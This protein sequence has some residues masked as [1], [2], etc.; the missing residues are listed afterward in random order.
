MKIFRW[1][2]DRIIQIT[3]FVSGAVLMSLEIVGAR[4]LIPFYGDT[5]YVWG[6]IIGIFL[7]SL[8]LGY[9][10][11]GKLADKKP[12]FRTLSYVLILAG[13]FV[14]LIPFIY[15]WVV[16]MVSGSPKPLAPFLAVLIIFFIP[17]LLHGVVSPFAIKLKARN[18]N[19]IGEL[20][21]GLYALSTLGSVFGTFLTTFI[22]IF[23]MPIHSIYYLLGAIL[24]LIALLLSR[25]N[26]LIIAVIFL[27]MI[28]QIGLF[29][30]SSDL[31]KT[32][33]DGENGATASVLVTKESLYGQIKVTEQEGVR[34]LYLNNGIMGQMW[35]EDETAILPG[36]EYVSC[37]EYP[38]TI[39]PKIKNILSLGL[40]IGMIGKSINSKYDVSLDV[41]EL[42]Q[43]VINVAK[44]YFNVETSENFKIY[45]DDAR[46]FLQNSDTKYDLIIMDVLHF[47]PS[48]GYQ[49]PFH[50]TT[51]E[52]FELVKEHL[53][54]D[55]IFSS[56]IVGSL[57]GP[58][59][60]S[61]YKTIDSVFGNVYAY[62]CGEIVLFAV[63]GNGFSD[64]LTQHFAH[65]EY[66]KLDSTSDD[67]ILLDDYAPV[68]PFKDLIIGNE[69]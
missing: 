28:L 16:S 1:K 61:E 48:Q 60:R 19:E 50:V 26:I 41:V 22:L 6:S 59:F 68:N 24:F 49:I 45:A 27:I 57:S 10:L 31:N 43:E 32:V 52:F 63:N 2:T 58:F 15:E 30:R 33:V 23:L 37:F 51:Q 18:I 62:N 46:T 9:Y 35:M 8:S 5:I 55:G 25:K 65:G 47:L 17:S 20:S 44:E 42:N 39:N 29:G 38:L 56:M 54:P 34:S 14:L 12:S 11:G 53:N 13:V 66:F 64:Q 36:W 69:I 3:V 4:T 7:L 21:G 67:I 40:G